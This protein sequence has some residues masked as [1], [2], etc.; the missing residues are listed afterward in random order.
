MTKKTRKKKSQIGD[1]PI[2]IKICYVCEKV[3]K[4]TQQFYTIGKGK[5]GKEMYRHRRCRASSYNQKKEK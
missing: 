1:G 4:I 5:D 2:E 3:I